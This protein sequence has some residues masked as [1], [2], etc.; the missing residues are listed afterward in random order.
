MVSTFSPWPAA[1]ADGGALVAFQDASRGVNAVRVARLDAAGRRR[2][3]P[4]AV[5]DA[6]A[7]PWNQWRPAL[8]LVPGSRA[9]AA[10]EDERDGPAQVFAARAPVARIG[11]TPRPFTGARR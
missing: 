4:S 6:G 9:L 2:G 10:W 5:S 1:L 3:T 7:A 8:A 11:G